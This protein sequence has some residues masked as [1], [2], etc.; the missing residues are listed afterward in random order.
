MNDDLNAFITRLEPGEGGSGPL[1]GRTL[2]VKDLIDT[3]G[4]RTTYGSE[5]Y[6]DHVPERRNQRDRLPGSCQSRVRHRW[7]GLKGLLRC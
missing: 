5:L 6:R 7:R 2:A 1:A 3:A 4:I